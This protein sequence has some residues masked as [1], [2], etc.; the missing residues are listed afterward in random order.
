MTTIEDLPQ[1]SI[2]DMSVDEALELLRSIRLS[3]RTS[4][5]L[6]KRKPPVKQVTQETMTPEKARLLLKRI[7]GE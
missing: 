7:L 1:R 5:S 3:R 2:S 4:K 6:T